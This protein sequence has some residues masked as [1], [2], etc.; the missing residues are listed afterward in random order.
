MFQR[1]GSLAVD[2]G[3]SRVISTGSA[4][5]GRAGG[6]LSAPLTLT[7]SCGRRHV[8]S[9]W[10]DRA[11]SGVFD[12]AVDCS[13]PV[14]SA[15]PLRVFCSE[16]RRVLVLCVLCSL[17][18][19]FSPPLGAGCRRLSCDRRPRVSTA[20]PSRNPLTALFNVATRL[21]SKCAT[22]KEDAHEQPTRLPRRRGV[23]M[24]RRRLKITP[25]IQRSSQAPGATENVFKWNGADDAETLKDQ[26][27]STEY[28]RH[29]GNNL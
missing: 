15:Q 1:R 2:T 18:W 13:L 25:G 9:V 8:E 11:T 6:N 26:I 24:C 23:V 5:W 28:T 29:W 19:M 14:A 22:L 7:S 16:R 27:N 12:E 17:A 3:S 20:F 10:E 21:P 4:P